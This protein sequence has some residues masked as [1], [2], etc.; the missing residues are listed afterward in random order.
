MALDLLLGPGNWSEFNDEDYVMITESYQRSSNLFRPGYSEKLESINLQDGK[1]HTT[2]YLNNSIL[3]RKE[4][5]AKYCVIPSQSSTIANQEYLEYQD[6]FVTTNVNGEICLWDWQKKPS[7][8][9]LTFIGSSGELFALT[10]EFY[11]MAVTPGA[12][13]ISFRKNGQSFGFEQFD[14]KFN[15]PDIV[16]NQFE[17]TDPSLINAYHQAYLKRLK[18]MNFTEDM[19]KDDFHLPEIEIKNFE[20]MPA[21]IDK[22]SIDLNL[23][24]EDSKYPLD[25]IN[26]WVNDVAILGT[27]G[28]SLRDLE[29]QNTNK[30]VTIPLAKGKNK[31][32]VSVLNQAGAESYKET[33]EIECTAGKTQPDLY[34]ITIGESKFEQSEY[35]LTYAAKDAEDMASL[36]KDSKVYNTIFTKTLVNEQVTKE[37]IAGLS[38]FLEQ[39]D[40]NDQVLVFFAGH[41]VL[42]T[43]LDYYLAAYD[44]DF[45]LPEK[46]GIVYEDLEKL[47]DGIKPLQKTLIIDACHSGEIDKEEVL[48]SQNDQVEDGDIQF[49]AVGNAVKSKLGSQNTMELTKSL[50]TDLRKGTGATVISSAGGMEF[51]MESGDWQNG[52]FTYAL[53]NGI[54]SGQADLNKDGEIWLSE[55][56]K[57][58][59]E[60]V[61]SLSNGKQ[62][63]TSRIENQIVDFRV[64]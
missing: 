1:Y 3:I 53:L 62:Q 36:F 18:K 12:S 56:R 20:S 57:Y 10:P 7:K 42:S 40:I 16:L 29:T 15:R 9:S 60:T 39:A 33:I 38:T 32:Q 4:N 35:N 59:G 26:I 37:N 25:R 61:T 64:W 24:L 43:D 27:N 46:R 13:K 31:V 21:I 23:H 11:Y 51:A 19:L 28:I 44:M 63:P 45:N 55:L 6:L 41:G 30:K 52:L 49:R 50:F 14:L 47:L 34:L 54:K 17:F 22:N 8:P 5:K 48:L 2:L 58:V